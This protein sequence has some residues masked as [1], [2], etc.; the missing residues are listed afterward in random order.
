MG[1]QAE[2]LRLALKF[3]AEPTRYFL[4]APPA[5]I[6]RMHSIEFTCG[7]CNAV[8]MHADEGQVHDLVIRCTVCGGF[9]S[10]DW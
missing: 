1:D 7:T 4:A 2:P 10:T 9:N 5:L 6:A 8:L 3:V